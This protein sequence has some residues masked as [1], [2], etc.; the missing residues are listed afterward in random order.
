MNNN[1]NN[2]NST[3]G[4]RENKMHRLKCMKTKAKRFNLEGDFLDCKN[5]LKEELAN[6]N[7]RGILNEC[8]L[9]CTCLSFLGLAKNN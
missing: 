5:F 9:K 8:V 6:K 2:N 1:S 4:E 7:C 3:Q